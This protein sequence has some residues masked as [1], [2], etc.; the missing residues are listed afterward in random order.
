MKAAA[1]DL[2]AGQSEGVCQ[3]FHWHAASYVDNTQAAS[4]RTHRKA[5]MDLTRILR[6]LLDVPGVLD[7]FVATRQYLTLLLH[8]WTTKDD[9]SL[10]LIDLA[11]EGEPILSILMQTLD[12]TGGNIRGFDRLL[13][14]LASSKLEASRFALAYTGRVTQVRHLV[15]SP[16]PPKEVWTFSQ[17][18]INILER[19]LDVGEASHMVRRSFEKSN[20]I[21]ECA[22]LLNSIVVAFEQEKVPEGARFSLYDL[23][24]LLQQLSRSTSSQRLDY[25]VMVRFR[26]HTFT[27]VMALPVDLLTFRRTVDN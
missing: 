15:S 13:E 1:V 2:I 26:V 20:F 16:D 11:P 18:I 5:Y 8:L 24:P 27:A 17:N 23:I 12:N 14:R 22:L 3:W 4:P 7:V 9:Q 21:T 10:Y 6:D 25:T 19:I